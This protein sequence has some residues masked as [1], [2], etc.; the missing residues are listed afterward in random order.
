MA[1]LSCRAIRVLAFGD[2]ED[3]ATWREAIGSGNAC[4]MVGKLLSSM[5]SRFVELDVVERAEAEE[6]PARAEGDAEEAEGGDFL[7]AIAHLFAEP[8]GGGEGQEA[9]AAEGALSRDPELEA[10][11]PAPADPTHLSMVLNAAC[12]LAFHHPGNQERL[13]EHAAAEAALQV[14]PLAHAQGPA[15][16]GRLLAMHACALLHALAWRAPAAQAR[17]G[18]LGACEALAAVLRAECVEAEAPVVTA[19]TAPTASA[20]PSPTANPSEEQ[21]QEEG[22]ERGEQ[23]EGEKAAPADHEAIPPSSAAPDRSLLIYATAAIGWLACEGSNRARLAAGG[24]CALLCAC[25]RAAGA[26]AAP[27]LRA[28]ALRA[29]GCLAAGGA[30]E[31]T[32]QQALV[33]A[34]ACEVLVAALRAEV[35]GEGQDSSNNMLAFLLCAVSNVSL[36]QRETQRAFG[37]AGAVALAASW[38]AVER[39]PKQACE[40]LL[41]LCTRCWPN[42]RRARAAGAAEAL[43]RLL[44]LPQEQ[45][46]VSE[47]TLV[48]ALACMEAPEA[49]VSAV[50]AE[51]TGAEVVAPAV[52]LQEGGELRSPTPCVEGGEGE[53]VWGIGGQD[54]GPAEEEGEEEDS[55]LGR[56]AVTVPDLGLTRAESQQSADTEEAE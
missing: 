41:V 13:L 51:S 25:V 16:G 12:A 17:M 35:E 28:H 46:G 9:L 15:T 55:P 31:P 22:A 43:A 4:S 47:K 54:D 36:G 19:P 20:S 3:S 34:G 24:V 49:V 42:Q 40:A 33:Q 6:A 23:Q 18:E 38:S 32:M 48:A 5:A 11:A 10:P 50:R 8:E 14:L 29:L 2:G 26:T 30:A 39:A 21:L 45:R 52:Q 7:A 44:A 53:Q 27:L 56:L 37:E 1:M